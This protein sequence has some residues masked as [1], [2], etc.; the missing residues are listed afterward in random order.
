MELLPE[1]PLKRSAAGNSNLI[2]TL[3]G[4][5]VTSHH[6]ADSFTWKPCQVLITLWDPEVG[7]RQYTEEHV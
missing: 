1:I 7:R 4:P 3:S 5:P 2:L 6:K